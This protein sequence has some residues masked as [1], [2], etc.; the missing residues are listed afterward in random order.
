MDFFIQVGSFL[1]W[2]PLKVL[3]IAA[4]L[5]NGAKK[6]AVVFAYTVLTFLIAVS[7]MAN[8]VANRSTSRKLSD[9]S[10]LVHSVGQ[11]LTYALIVAV[12]ISLIY[13][14]TA[15]LAIGHLIRLVSTAGGVL[16]VVGAF[17]VHYDPNVLMG[18]WM[19]PWVR[20]LNFF[21]AILDLI[22]WALL[23]T[24]REKD[25]RLLMLTGGMGIMFAGEAIANAIR[26]VAIRWRSIPTYRSAVIFA[27]LADAMY[28][29]IWW[30]AFR[31]ES[32]KKPVDKFRPRVDVAPAPALSNRARSSRAPSSTSNH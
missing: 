32:S 11:G 18:V 6:Y 16:F 12:V 19:A 14:A 30:Q 9:S 26:S 23:L 8:A 7:Q 31:Q 4:I 20:D 29:Y 10:Q 27:L 1:V 25:R 17:W 3:V 24:A 28:L 5:R 22:L 21:A 2:L 15:K 13:G